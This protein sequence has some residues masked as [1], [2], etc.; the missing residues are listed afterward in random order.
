MGNYDQMA[1]AVSE[2]SGGKNVVLL[3]DIGMPSIYVR[4]PKGKNSELVSGLSDNVHYAFN[5]DSVEKTAFYYSKYQNIIV[6]ERAYSLGHRDPA[7][8]IN[9]DAARKACENKG[10]GFHLATMAEWAYIA[11]WCRKNG[12]MP[13]GNNNY[14]KDS[15][16]THEHGEESSKDSG[17]TGRCFTGSGPVTWNHNH[18]GDG[19]CDLNGNVWEWNAGMRLVDGEIQIIPYNNAAMG[20]KCDMSASSTLWKAIKADRGQLKSMQRL[21]GWVD[22]VEKSGERWYYLK[23]DVEKFFYRMDHEVLMSIIRKK[24]GDKEAV[25][26]LE[27]YVCHASRAFGLPLGVKSPLE[28]SDKEMLWDVGI[29][30]GGGLSHMYGNMYLN[31]MDQMAK[32]KEGIQYYIRYMDDVIILSTDKELLHRYK[33]MFSD[34]LGDVLKLRLNNKTAIRPVS[35]G[36][37]FVGYTI[38][39][40]DVRLRKSTS[41]RMKRHLKTIQ[42]LYR[43]YEI[44][45]DRARSTLM[46]YKALM[47]HC[48]CRALEKKIFEDFVLTHNPKEADTDNG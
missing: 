37:E 43:D 40:F 34:F 2:L 10:A 19:I 6:N 35:H 7:N 22:F 12:T 30:I 45:L 21:A 4:I 44:D 23:M 26:F 36:M 33:N 13:H 31:P 32:R 14:G 41:L 3:D 25:R 29:A 38:R 15:A 1:A 27:H 5:V 17:K 8:S 20:S 47:D 11:L 48:D 46:S 16:Y 28:I 18:H 24:I 39:P 9:W 42:E